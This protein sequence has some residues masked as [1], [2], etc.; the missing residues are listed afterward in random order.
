MLFVEVAPVL[1]IMWPRMG[2]TRQAIAGIGLYPITSVLI[3]DIGQ[4]T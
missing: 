2:T 4:V 1:I 3:W